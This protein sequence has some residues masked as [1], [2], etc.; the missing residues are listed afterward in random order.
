M[1]HHLCFF[2]SLISG[3]CQLNIQRV[4]I[5]FCQS[6]QR[7]ARNSQQ[8][9]IS[10]N[11]PSLIFNTCQILQRHFNSRSEKFISALN[12]KSRDRKFKKKLHFDDLASVLCIKSAI[13]LK[14]LIET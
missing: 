8:G 1:D 3:E 10:A 13:Q 11:D 9:W 12:R 4:S 6:I 5:R 2:H 7:N 14:I